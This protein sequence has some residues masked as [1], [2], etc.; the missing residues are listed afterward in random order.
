MRI[1]SQVEDLPVLDMVAL[2]K[3]SM[4]PVKLKF[5]PD[6]DTPAFNKKLHILS[7]IEGEE[8]NSTCLYD[9]IISLRLGLDIECCPYHSWWFHVCI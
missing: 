6:F 2:I 7:Q 1:V 9:Y 3:N 4:F 8:S 5:L